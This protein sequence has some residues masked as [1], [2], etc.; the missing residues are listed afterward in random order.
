MKKSA[1]VIKKWAVRAVVAIGAMFT[2][3]AC[4][5]GNMCE[6]G[7]PSDSDSDSTAVSQSKDSVQTNNADISESTDNQGLK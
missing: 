2:V 4:V 1:F 6:Y 5:H 7:P 3:S